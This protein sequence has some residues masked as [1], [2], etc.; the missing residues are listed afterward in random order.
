V[1]PNG[2]NAHVTVKPPGWWAERIIEAAS[3]WRGQRYIFVVSERRRGF[4]KMAAK[5][6]SKDKLKMT[7]IAGP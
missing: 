6:L 2:W 1:L 4:E 3:G 5:I 7:E